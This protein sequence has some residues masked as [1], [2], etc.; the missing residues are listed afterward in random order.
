MIARLSK[1]I[2]ELIDTVNK[3]PWENIKVGFPRAIH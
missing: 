1:E 2:L 3:L